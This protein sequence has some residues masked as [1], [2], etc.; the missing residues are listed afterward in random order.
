MPSTT[1]TLGEHA[2]VLGASVAG[3]LA[4]RALADSFPRVTVV[5]R[6]ELP[7]GAAARRGVP[8]GR[9]VHALLARGRQI[10]DEFFPDLPARLVAE[11]AQSADGLAS[12]RFA[13]GGH[14]FPQAPSGLIDVFCSRLFLE[15]HLREAVR[16]MPGVTIVE[17]C[18]VLHPIVDRTRVT[19][20][21]VRHRD[22][23][24]AKEILPAE[25]LV[26]ATGR[27]SRTPVWLAELGRTPPPE[28]RVAVDVGY[29]TG[30]FRL[31]PGALG[32]DIGILISACPGNPRMGGLFAVEGGEVTA[33]VAGTLGD[34]PPTEFAGFLDFAA[35]LAY[36]DLRD[37]LEGAELVGALAS[38]RFPANTRRHYE[39]LDDLPAGLFVVGD[40]LAAFNPIYGQGMTLAAIEAA[41]LRRLL[42]RG[43]VPTP[44][45][46]FRAAARALAPAWD[47]AVGSD[48]RA[49]RVAG[50]RTR[51]GRLVNAYV[52]R[53]QAA[54]AHDA[55]L[56]RTFLEVS[57]LVAP[58]KALLRP[59]RMVRVLARGRRHGA[60]A[61]EPAER[62][63]AA[64]PA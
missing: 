50:P 53:F 46:Y 5:E 14:R 59:D 30:R 28:T 49:P 25:V 61:R 54:A 45:E 47:L 57:G 56:A 22:A 40:A 8:Q 52:A 31:R 15:H 43:R 63:V 1:P 11:G 29:L 9:Q 18:D 12:I 2:V 21:A 23:A 16:A 44:K 58:P 34:H 60:A 64:R 55:D 37:A 35:T 13:F 38:A 27:G 24:P 7:T 48:L 41:E 51:A 33:G 36:P 6:D 3:L 26:D 32:D 39:R 17:R 62:S 42:G 19:G 20:V 4:A 10:L